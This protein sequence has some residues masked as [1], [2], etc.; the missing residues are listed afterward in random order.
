MNLQDLLALISNAEFFPIDNDSSNL[1]LDAEIDGE[2]LGFTRSQGAEWAFMNND[3][4][5]MT[6][7][8]ADY[9]SVEPD[10]LWPAIAPALTLRAKREQCGA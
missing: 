2:Q 8:V 10:T 6:E 1:L 4:Y 7:T 3:N 9:F 5:E